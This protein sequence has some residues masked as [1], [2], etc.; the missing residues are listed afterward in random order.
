MVSIH[1]GKVLGAQ[2]QVLH[3]P[4]CVSTHS[5]KPCTPYAGR[6]MLTL[7][8]WLATHPCLAAAVQETARRRRP[9]LRP[10]SMRAVAPVLGSGGSG[11]VTDGMEVLLDALD[12]A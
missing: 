7:V 12:R 3:S 9:T 2:L 10:I 5:S 1:E 8:T 6:A 11:P 4:P